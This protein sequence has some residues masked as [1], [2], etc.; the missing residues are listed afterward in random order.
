MSETDGRAHDVHGDVAAADDDD[1]LAVEVRHVVIADGTQHHDG[2]HDVA[3]V[4]AGDADLFVLMGADGDIDAVI[5]MLE[6]FKPDV[7]ANGHAGVD[8]NAGGEDGLDLL[9]KELSREAVARDAVAEHAAELLALFVDGHGVAHQSQIVRAA[10]AARAPMT[11]TFLPVG[12]AQGGF[13]TS[14]AWSTA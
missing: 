1:L 13:G 10:Q 12:G 8:L 4:L 11:A 9:V 2:G 7:L 3:A 14:P 6:L 5:L